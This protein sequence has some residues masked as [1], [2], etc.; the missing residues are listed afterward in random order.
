MPKNSPRRGY[1]HMHIAIPKE[2]TTDEQRVA[3]V[4]SL[5]KELT[6]LGCRVLMQKGAGIGADYPDESYVGVQFFEDASSL[7]QKADIILKVQPPTLKEV[8]LFKKNSVL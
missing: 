8:A 3:M 4:P 5:V 2:I 1:Y 6:Q 7:Y